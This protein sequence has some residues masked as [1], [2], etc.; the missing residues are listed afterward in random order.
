L[1]YTAVSE[2]RTESIIRAMN[3]KAPLDIITIVLMIQIVRTS[4]TSD[5]FE[6]ASRYIPEDY[7]HACRRKNLKS[8]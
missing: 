8:H 7:L 6:T 2:V 1:K 5:Y 4:E 3:M